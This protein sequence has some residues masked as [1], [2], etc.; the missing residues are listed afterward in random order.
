MEEVKDILKK[1]EAIQALAALEPVALDVTKLVDKACAAPDVT[2][3]LTARAKIEELVKDTADA[4][5]KK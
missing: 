1:D 3:E 4:E 5:I 2:D